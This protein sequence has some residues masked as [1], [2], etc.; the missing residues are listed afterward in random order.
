MENFIAFIHK[1]NKRFY[2]LR[3]SEFGV[4]K[5]EK[6]LKLITVSCLAYALA[7]PFLIRAGRFSFEMDNISIEFAALAIVNILV[8]FIGISTRNLKR[9]TLKTA[10][11]RE[12]RGRFLQ[13]LTWL[14]VCGMYAWSILALYFSI[15]EERAANFYTWMIVAMVIV[16][17]FTLNVYE[18]LM[19]NAFALVSIIIKMSRHPNAMYN[20]TQIYNILI[21]TF[22][23]TYLMIN[24]YI[25]LLRDY[26]QRCRIEETQKEKEMFMVGMTH[27]MRTP[28][29]AVLGKNQIILNDTTEP[30]I[31]ELA[32]EIDSG[33]KH[34]LSLIN[35][36]LDLSK[37]E[38]GKM[39]ITP[40]DYDTYEISY[41]MAE[42]IRGE[43]KNKGLGFKLSVD[44]NIP[45]LLH[46][47]DV[48]IKQVL[49]NL[50][51]NAI[52]YTNEG[53]VTMKMSFDYSNQAEKKG[54]LK[55]EVV[56]TGIGIKEEDLPKLAKAFSRVDEEKNRNVRGT[57]LGLAITSQLLKLMGSEL[58]VES[59]YGSGS[60]FF[61]SLPQNVVNEEPL[62]AAKPK[63][64]A[65]TLE[66]FKIKDASVLVVDD[67]QVN[68]SVCKGLMKYYG[69]MPDYA[70]SGEKCLQMCKD[71]KYD[72]I[73]LD[74]LMPEMDGIETLK[75]LKE[76]LGE[77]LAN[78]PILALT[79]N[80]SSDSE[81]EY[82][83]YG[84]T[85]YLAKPINPVKLQNI[86]K[87]IFKDRIEREEQ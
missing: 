12:R 46:G 5:R 85:G 81:N 86:F 14:E 58:Q 61:F 11:G 32:K 35:D 22:I 57:G 59:T 37:M 52:K 39:S 80:E 8:A 41:E 51:S 78:T 67:N 40:V 16:V 1:I 64:N 36:L 44:D 79:A 71:K 76:N 10:K 48:R 33:G 70:N 15:V 43:A 83:N 49:M 56:D 63:D 69:V 66:K 3:N 17:V 21:F 75:A 6:A 60:K 45:S 73:F 13:H 23:L 82:K 62:T 27:E 87:E 74:H 47:D 7:A 19:F 42:M 20:S 72:I 18:S 68:Y 9:Y 34:L 4:L 2:G 55:V 65:E 30:N 29:T 54:F 53:S 38:S 24:K 31:K 84:F 50:L 77:N 28:L 25:T 26:N